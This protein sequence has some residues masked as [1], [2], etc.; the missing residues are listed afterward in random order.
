MSEPA[1]SSRRNVGL[2]GLVTLT[3]MFLAFASPAMGQANTATVFGRV[4]DEQGALIQDAT[5]EIRNVDTNIVAVSKTNKVGLYTVPNLPP[6]HY[7]ITVSKQ[8][9]R[10]V[11]ATGATLEVQDNVTR[12]FVLQVGALSESVTVSASATNIN[13][14]DA[15]VSTVIDPKLVQE[16]PLNGRSFQGLFQLTPGVTITPTSNNTQ[17]QFSVNGQRTNANYFLVDGASANAGISASGGNGQTFGGSLPA[18]SALGGTNTL[19]STEAVQEFAIQT[20]TYAPEFGRTPGAQ[21]SIVTRSGTNDFHGNVFDYLRNDFFDAN[22]W[23]AN[24]KVLPRAALRQNDFGGVLGG[25]LF[26][27]KTFFFF[28]YEG[29]RL[30]QPTTG[31]SDVPTVAIRSAAPASRQP[32]FNAYPLPNGA[33]EGN[34]LAPANYTFSNPSGLDAVSIRIDHHFTDSL[35]VF[36]RYNNA[37]SDT[38]QRGGGGARTLN[39]VAVTSAT[40]QSATIG[41]A[42]LARP[43]LTE[44]VRFNWTRVSGAGSFQL[45]NFAGADPSGVQALLPSPFT[46]NDS[47]EVVALDLNGQNPILTVG[48]ILSNVQHQMNIVDNVALQAGRHLMKFGLDYRRLT[49]QTSPAAYTQ[50]AE[51]ATIQSALTANATIG[52][53]QAR[54]AVNAAFNNYSLYAQDTWR[55]HSRTSLTYGLR[56]DYNPAPDALGSN[57]LSP[58]AIQGID[59]PKTLSFAP[60]GTPLYHATVNNFGPRLGVAHEVRSDPK[61]QLVLR[62]GAGIF[63]DLGNGPSGTAFTNFPFLSQK[64]VG[65]HPF[66]FSAADATPVAITANPPVTAITVFPSTLKAPYTEQW[67]LSLEQSVGTQQTVT[68]G[69]IGAA[70]HS[71]LDPQLFL[72]PNLPPGFGQVTFVSNAGFSRYDALQ[73]QFRRRTSKGLGVIASYTWAHALDNISTD[74]GVSVPGQF[75]D[76]R[77][78]YASSDNDIRHTGALALDYD[79]PNRADSRLLRTLLSGWSV[80]PVVT[81]RSSPPINVFFLRNIG[82]GNYSF[83][84]DLVPGVPLYLDSSAIPGGRQINASALTVPAAQ[85]QGDLGRNAYRGFALVQADLAVRRHFRLTERL[86]LQARAEAFNVLNHPNFSPQSGFL[87]VVTAAGQLVV[88]NTFGTTQSMFG[89][90]LNTTGFGSGFSPL[91]QTGGSRSLQ[92]ALKLEF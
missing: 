62:A 39:T 28:S 9:F 61:T 71:L 82:F 86:G 79:I 27:S 11:T 48:R 7:V 47:E 75:L 84:P 1:C 18:F 30:R 13:T 58:F 14:V 73:A 45:D 21:V 26:K 65:G 59:N 16:L 17:G 87:G 80:D 25:P 6:G 81:A 55:I 38:K 44:D 51:F 49:P 23:F 32:L 70:G 4:T 19:V 5:I 24:Q 29:L 85:R 77:I 42:W 78:D 35:S 67:N 89:Q 46:T 40:N 72:Q 83:R 92:L 68:V 3:L 33:D 76:P 88:Q 34:G 8:G 90:G 74:A 37:P 69:Y 54:A 63:Y 57:G 53:I 2:G 64:L 22:D 41:F 56:W 36:G 52:V 12:N 31:L 10:S 60:A 15:S 43:N 20:S 50:L 66:P 91:Y